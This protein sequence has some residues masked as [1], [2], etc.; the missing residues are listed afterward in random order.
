V[1]CGDAKVIP[2][3][4]FLAKFLFIFAFLSCISQAW[5]QGDQRVIIVSF[6]G[7]GANVA[8]QVELP[9]IERIKKEGVYS[10]QA[11]TV[12]PSITLV[13]HTSMLTGLSPARHKIDWNDWKPEKGY[14]K[15]ETIFELAKKAGLSTAMVVGKEKF[16]QLLKEGTVDKFVMGKNAAEVGKISAEL[17]AKEKP[18]LL[19]VHFA[20]IDSAGHKYGWL[21]KEQ[22]TAALESDAGLGELIKA[23][24]DAKLWATTTLILSS[25]HGGHEKTHGTAADSD[26]L[27]PWMAFGAKAPKGKPL[28]KKIMT[29]DTAP[30]ALWIL[31]LPAP[32]DWDG[33]NILTQ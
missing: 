15:V 18:N 32:K 30:T 7:Y 28:P 9:Q 4:Y 5:A 8:S 27:I 21:T 10:F 6:D 11:E 29:Y 14:V 20:D 26:R 3:K 31:G 16:R 12:F 13:S 24:D 23:V 22:N 1:V 2:M 25:D 33:K 19:F 17:F